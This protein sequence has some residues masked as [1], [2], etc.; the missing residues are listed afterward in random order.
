M[1]IMISRERLEKLKAYEALEEQ[2]DLTR[3]EIVAC[4]H[5]QQNQA[6][7]VYQELFHTEYQEHQYSG[8]LEED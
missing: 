6:P 7:A 1:P 2:Y 3:E 8:P 5:E 4:I